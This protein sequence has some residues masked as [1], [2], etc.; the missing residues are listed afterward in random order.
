MFDDH[1]K[2]VKGWYS[3]LGARWYNPF[4]R[5][6]T[7]AVAGRAEKRLVKT[8]EEVCTPKTRI[9]ELGC[10][11]GINIGRIL[12]QNIP[13]RSYTGLDFSEDMLSIAKERFGSDKRVSLRQQDITTGPGREKYDV[14][15]STWV[16][17]HLEDPSG[18]INRHH[19]QL[20]RKG[21][22]LLVF[23]GR[24]RWY[25]NFCSIPLPVFSPPG[26]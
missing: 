12:R 25:I 5:V 14:L 16:L 3:L 23:L 4:R 19:R 8:L 24:P 11:T 2:N 1:E 26:T 13:F 7:W 15:I 10:G 21:I 22:I 17:S 6:W 9:L 20:N 18:V